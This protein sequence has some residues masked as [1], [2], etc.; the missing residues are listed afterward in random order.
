MNYYVLQVA[1][2]EEEKTE[3]HIRKM[4]SSSLYDQCF[5]PMRLIR[6][7]IHGR[8]VDIHEKLMPGYIFVTT[9]NAEVLCI[10][11]KKIPLLTK[12]LGK[13]LGYFVRLSDRE[14]RW[15]DLLLQGKKENDACESNEVGLSQIDIR[16]GNEIRI[17]SGPL[18]D[19][20]GMVKKINL[21]K[22][23][24]EVEVP[25]MNGNTVIHLGVEMVER[26]IGKA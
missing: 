24:A 26:K 21:H 8:W 13:D 9:E 16:E 14:E 22:M 11:L 18:V 20:E 17:V 3:A 10:Q 6:K 15:L 12:M 4:V 19:M 25:F 5:H 1:P 2:R 7:K 23:I